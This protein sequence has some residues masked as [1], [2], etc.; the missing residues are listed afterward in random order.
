VLQLIKADPTQLEQVL[1]NLS[2]SDTGI[3]T[4]LGRILREILASS[5]VAAPSAALSGELGYA[6]DL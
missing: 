5:S 1:M 4:S 3:G 6:M 2:V